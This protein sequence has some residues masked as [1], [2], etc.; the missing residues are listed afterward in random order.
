[1]SEDE[2]RKWPAA[3]QAA[4]RRVGVGAVVV[5]VSA[6]GAPGAAPA[7]GVVSHVLTAD[8]VQ[9]APASHDP[10]DL[11][12]DHRDQEPGPVTASGLYSAGGSISTLQV[13]QPERSLPGALPTTL[14]HG[15]PWRPVAGSVPTFW[16]G[17]SRRTALGA[18]RGTGRAA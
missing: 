15:P 9:M 1:M 10:G 17:L 8:L 3:L 18:Q 12:H 4:G 6:G 14:V 2:R 13:S 7:A 11:L 16:A 5:G